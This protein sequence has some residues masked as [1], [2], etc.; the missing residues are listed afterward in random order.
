MPSYGMGNGVLPAVIEAVA[1][2]GGEV[3]HEAGVFAPKAG[4]LLRVLPETGGEAGHVGGA[5]RRCFAFDGT[6]HGDA[7]NTGL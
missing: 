2:G 6:A 4:K 7:E 5:E 3:G 1:F